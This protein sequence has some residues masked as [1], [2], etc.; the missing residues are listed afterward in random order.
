MY[1]QDWKCLYNSSTKAHPTTKISI[2]QVYRYQVW[3]PPMTFCLI[4]KAVLNKKGEKGKVK[5]LHMGFI[6]PQSNHQKCFAINIKLINLKKSSHILSSFTQKI[7]GEE[8]ISYLN[9]WL[10]HL[11]MCTMKYAQMKE[12]FQMKMNFLIKILFVN[13]LKW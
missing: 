2:G 3:F 10:Y 5:T 7:Y 1:R 9:L 12:F 8:L 11:Y 13:F 4:P 6:Y